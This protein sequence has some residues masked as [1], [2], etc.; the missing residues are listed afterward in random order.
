MNRDWYKALTWMMWLILLATALNYWREW[1]RLP[2][3][4]AVHFDANW[5]PN[6]YASREGAVMLG[7]G[8]M[9]VIVAVFTIAALTAR[10]FR[11]I[12]SWPLLVIAYVVLGFAWFGNYYIV[13]FN[14]STPSVHS[15][16]GTSTR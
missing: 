5:H 2:N 10:A 7:L 1:D 13:Q 6:G 4:M 12:A 3:L 15:E 16:Q 14:L 11:S 9:T 8:I